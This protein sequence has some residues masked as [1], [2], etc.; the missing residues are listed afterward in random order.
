MTGR[1]FFSAISGLRNQQVKL[2]VIAN[3]IANLNTFGFKSSRVTFADLL[4]Q[5]LRAAS[6]PIGGLGGTN[7]IQVGLGSKLAS[8]DTNIN[9][10]SIQSTGNL[11]DLGINGEGFF[12]VSDGTNRYYTRAGNFSLDATGGMIDTNGYRVQGFTSRTSDGL[13]ISDSLSP[14][15]II[16]NFGEKLEA[17]ATTTV[18]YRSNLD[19]SSFTFGSA[20][21]QTAGS[22]GLT[23]A[24]GIM[25]PI[26][27]TQ[28]SIVAATFTIP[29]TTL[30]P[31]DDLVINGQVIEVTFP[32]T[33]VWGDPVANAQYVAEQINDQSTTVYARG[34]SDGSVRIDSLYGGASDVII[35]GVPAYLTQV[36]LTPAT[37]T[38]PE[39][40][41]A[42]AGAHTITVTDATAAR[43]TTITPV[44]AGVL[45]ANSI[46][47]NGVTISYNLTASTNTS[48]Q[49]AAHIA[50]AIN[51]A[52]G[53]NVQATGNANGTITLQ[54][55]IAGEPN[56]IRIDDALNLAILGLDTVG[57]YET[58]PVPPPAGY[59]VVANGINASISNAF[60]PE[61][62]SA[63]FQ[64]MVE[65]NPPVG[66]PSTLA[67]LALLVI[68]E[69]PTFPLIPGVILT[70]DELFPGQAT[71]ITHDAY[72]HQASIDVFDSLGSAHNL[73]LT[74]KHVGEN[75][76]DWTADMPDEPN[77]VLTNSTGTLVFGASGLIGGAN[78]MNPITFSPLGATAMT[79]HPIFN[80]NGELLKGVTQFSS[81]STTS[82][83]D[84][85]GWTMGILQ[86]FAFDTTGVLRGIFSNGLTRPIARIAL[87]LFP[88]P[89]GLQ[90]RGDNTFFPS[91]NS[92][93]ASV[94][95]PGTGGAGVIIPG[96]LEQSNVDAATEFTELIIA[97]RSY[98]A[99]SRVI[100][101]QSELLQ[102][103]IN[104]IR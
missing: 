84:Q 63:G 22:T 31:G 34:M 23:T 11:T 59:Y 90:R 61:D 99:N 27:L 81:P 9:Q 74:F 42:L 33:W 25:V 36:G 93:L 54:Q 10:G 57:T 78:P 70:A 69:N 15:D 32:S 101:I 40:S 6:S 102:D 20:E 7:P 2:D 16:I 26:A 65:H 28:G 24:A 41:S 55:E 87:G 67:D 17:R 5:T 100:T 14:T 68:G 49:N 37:Y 92:G 89:G 98:Q 97:Q 82:A 51:A 66:L 18:N 48:A 91:A 47:I 60:I 94:L 83:E 73:L 96:A 88:N 8:I 38:A 13:E 3:N 62:G 43:A 12:I 35:A 64:R 104:L 58:E 56:E 85:D 44:A 4:S 72:E 29:D 50:A 19:S 80:G 79:I 75:E 1:A 21:L 76:W 52:T 53:H 30:S 71:V 77:L 86:S 95:G 39:A 103:V 45:P 46:V